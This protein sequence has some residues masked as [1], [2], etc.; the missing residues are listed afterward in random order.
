MYIRKQMESYLIVLLGHLHIGYLTYGN[1]TQLVR[2]C[3]LPFSILAYV[4]MYPA[5]TKARG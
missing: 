4:M 1:T 3:F 5:M 2:L